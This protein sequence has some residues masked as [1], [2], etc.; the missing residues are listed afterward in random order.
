MSP[1]PLEQ[2]SD[3]LRNQRGL[4]TNTVITYRH[5][6][7]SYLRFLTEK[8]IAVTEIE[9]D[10]VLNFIESLRRENKRS[11]TLFVTHIAL[12]RFPDQ[13]VHRSGAFH[14]PLV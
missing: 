1:E 12:M 4:S 10:S 11:A 5:H 3:Y 8:G 14:P 7:R 2:F 6:A 9:K 13:F